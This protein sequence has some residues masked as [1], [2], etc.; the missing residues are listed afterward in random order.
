VTST[1]RV[2]IG[3]VLEGPLS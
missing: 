3:V 2:M 1:L